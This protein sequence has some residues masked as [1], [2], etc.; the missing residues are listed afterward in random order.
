MQ[1]HWLWGQGRTP[2]L[3][4]FRQRYQKSGKMITA[5]DLLRGL[6]AL[7][8]WERI[9]VPGATG[10]TDTDYAAKGRY[11][12]QA[13]GDSDIVSLQQDIRVS[14]ALHPMAAGF[15]AQQVI[16][17]APGPSG[18]EYE[19]Q[20]LRDSE[21]DEGTTIPFVRGPESEDEGAPAVLVLEEIASDLQ[22]IFIGFPVY[23]L[24]EPDRSRLVLN[25]ADW[26]VGPE[27][28]TGR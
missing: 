23:L 18:S 8:G 5:V 25:T 27:N 12:I 10:Y 13:I 26:L 11:A 15:D 20:L 3:A 9:E 19:T 28:E 6:A 17:F 21:P 22:V 4:P 16:P 14:D 1:W 2:Q 7:I 24:P